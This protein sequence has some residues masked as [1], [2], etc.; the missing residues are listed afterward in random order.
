MPCARAI[1]LLW[2][3]LL[4][5]LPAC[6]GAEQPRPNVLLVSID[7]LRA[8]HLSAYG[9]R[10]PTS[11]ALDELAQSGVLFERAISPTSWTLPAHLSM[12]TGL[13]IS[14][15][16]IADDRQWTFVGPDGEPV[17]PR[18]HGI[19]LPEF[20]REAGYRT[21]G[22]HTW[23]YLDEQ[24]GFGPGFEVYER[25]GHTFYSHPEVSKR[26]E[27]LRAANDVEGLKRLHDEHPALFDATRKTTPEV[28]E[29]AR[30]WIGAVRAQTP[31]QPFFCFLHLFDVHDP[32]VPP[33][34]FDTLFD[35]DYAGSLNGRNVTSPDSPVRGDMDPRDLEHLIALYDGEIAYVDSQLGQLFAWLEAQGLADDTLVIVTSDHGE[36]FFEHGHKTHRRQL[37]RESVHVP[38]ILAWPGELPAGLRIGGT[39]GLVDLTPTVL[40]LVGVAGPPW[41]SGRDL[42]QV[43]RGEAQPLERPYLTELYLFDTGPTARRQLGI[44]LG[45]EHVLL[46]ADGE[47][48][49]AIERFDYGTNPLGLGRGEM[50]APQDAQY[51]GASGRLAA[52]IEAI[53]A[54]RRA[55]PARAIEVG[56][57]L[58]ERD[59]AELRALGYVTSGAA[60]PAAPTRT[61]SADLLPAESGFW[62][63]GE[64]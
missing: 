44:H 34:P 42:S 2:L 63:G 23:K 38:W 28:L 11:P 3:A 31:A 30:E 45:D 40:G 58:T 14:A 21:A 57:G 47:Q 8:D 53:R 25:L 51:Q 56:A 6:G 37:Y 13:E 39:A 7:T 52:Q 50:L 16:G 29:R 22:F 5:G 32:Y 15:H 24:F 61:G 55:A 54:L 17:P 4:A 64:R 20:L 60:A 36:E 41:T 48:P 43:V 26:F 59:L 35:P 9:Y 33:P 10:R 12:L 18:L 62:D 27:A 19:F 46:V 49:F 1:A